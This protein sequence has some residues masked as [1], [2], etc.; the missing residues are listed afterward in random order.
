VESKEYCGKGQDI[1]MRIE[2]MTEPVG[3]KCNLG[4]K[5][6]KKEKLME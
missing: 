1:E 3:K 6:G 4:K 5:N 2:K